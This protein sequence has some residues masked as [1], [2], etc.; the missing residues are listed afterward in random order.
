MS[1][2]RK[3]IVNTIVS[4]LTG[5]IAI[6]S[7]YFIP[8]LN[9]EINDFVNSLFSVITVMAGIWITC[10]L[11]FL[12][13]H[14]DRYQ[15][16]LLEKDYM[17][18]INSVFYRIVYSVLLGLFVIVFDYGVV[19]SIW[20]AIVALSVMVDIFIR[21]Y[22]S[23]ETL[24]VNTY[25]DDFFEQISND[26]SG[27]KNSLDEETIEKIKYILDESVVKE[28]YFTAQNIVEKIGEIFR[29]FLS[30]SIKLNMAEK[31]EPIN[32]VFQ[33][34]ISLNIYQLKLC[35]K[36]KSEILISSIV[37]QQWKNIKFCL[38][39]SQYEWYKKYQKQFDEF[40][41]NMHKEDN[42]LLLNEL[43]YTYYLILRYLIKNK[44]H[45]H[46]EDS[47]AKILEL[48]FSL[49]FAYNKTNNTS[50]AK[51]ITNLLVYCIEND[52]KE[53]YSLLFDKLEEFTRII[54]KSSGVFKIIKIYYATLFNELI[55]TDVDRAYEYFEMISGYLPLSGED[56]ELIEFKQYCISELKKKK[57]E[58]SEFQ[59]KVFKHHIRTLNELIE[60]NND[61][62]GSVFL[63]N[64]I[65]YIDK[66]QYAASEKFSDFVLSIRELLKNSIV[67][68]NTPMFYSILLNVKNMISKTESRQKE[69]QKEL[70]DIYFWLFY[71]T[72]NLTNKQ[73]FEIS[74][75]LFYDSLE[76]LDKNRKI[77][78]DL[79]EQIID[80]LYGCTEL[81]C[82]ETY[83][84]VD[85]VIGILFD[86]LK[87]NK[88]FVFVSSSPSRKKQLFKIL[89]N[90]GT[91]CVE[92]SYEDGLRRVSNAIGWLIIYCIKQSTRDH[93]IYLLERADELYHIAINMQISHQT[94][95]FM[96]T[97]F[98]TI[99]TYCC[100][101][102]RKY[103]CYLNKVLAALKKEPKQNINVAVSLRTS[104]N[105]M[106]NGLFENQT[107]G[108]T[109]KFK[110]CVENCLEEST[111]NNKITQKKSTTSPKS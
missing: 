107:N 98:T 30:N 31:K 105:D 108:L 5:V 87:E 3:L 35:K 4:I 83:E 22:K 80:N 84:L 100:K 94:R 64:F 48:T 17:S 20:F 53:I 55:E 47:L 63:P 77:S 75:E 23:K 68:S 89:F 91:N 82:K 72:R 29:D 79:G 49:I 26:L 111:A 50:F 24:M 97:L 2:K 36:I 99:G 59:E 70:F 106:W 69:I 8:T 43:Y 28:E 67:K 1:R 92:N 33:R 90:I 38:E 27:S 60:L 96:L 15:L 78:A 61:Y 6:V 95:I 21:V 58:N 104:E 45:E 19:S 81:I 102:S 85:R 10:Y 18:N 40:V 12:E 54:Q 37:K 86:F 34:I 44:K 110:C 42:V 7:D 14:K 88:E 103:S 71:Y 39:N 41:F 76:D 57:P 101:D 51:L 65:S 66:Y 11:L 73:Y 74:F 9:L 46:F 52:E 56:S 25:V 93:A 13:L 62:N 32:D 109:A 16:K